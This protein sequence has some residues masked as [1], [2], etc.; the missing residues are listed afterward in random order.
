MSYFWK[1]DNITLRLAQAS[2]WIYFYEN[3][4]ESETRFLYYTESFP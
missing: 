2:D 3:Y 1:K 4:F